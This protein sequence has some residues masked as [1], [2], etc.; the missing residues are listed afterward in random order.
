MP[1]FLIRGLA[2]YFAA[3][4]MESRA[5]RQSSYTP[6]SETSSDDDKQI[7]SADL[8][9]WQT[10]M[11]WLIP[12]VQATEYQIV[13]DN[14]K[15]HEQIIIDK[16]TK[17]LPELTLDWMQKYDKQELLEW[18]ANEKKRQ[19]QEE[20]DRQ[21]KLEAR[22]IEEAR[23]RARFGSSFTLG[24]QDIQDENKISQND[25]KGNYVI[26]ILCVLVFI[27]ALIGLWVYNSPIFDEKRHERDVHKYAAIM[28]EAANAPMTEIV[29]PD[30]L[31]F[32]MNEEEFNSLKEQRK[33][34]IDNLFGTHYD[35]LL[36]NVHYIGDAV[37]GD[38]YNDNKLSSYT[39]RIIGQ[40]SNGTFTYLTNNDV[41]NICNYY[42][43]CLKEDYTL[44][45][46]PDLFLWEKAHNYI[47]TKNN[48]VIELRYSERYS[49]SLTIT[50]KNL[51]FSTSNEIKSTSHYEERLSSTQ[52]ES[53]DEEPITSVLTYSSDSSS[54]TVHPRGCYNSI[55]M[56]WVEGGVFSM[57]DHDGYDNKPEH[58]V[59]VSN[60]Y[61]ATTE[62]TQSLWRE[63]MGT[64]GSNLA[65]RLHAPQKPADNISWDD[66]H[67]FIDALN[68]RTDLNF[69][70][71]TEA[72][73]E[74]AAKGGNKSCGYTYSE[75]DYIN[76]VAWWAVNA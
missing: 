63:I 30:C 19:Q 50:C 73:W 5:R 61:I 72:E 29:T 9:S 70:L 45:N 20:V 14:P 7:S 10:Q 15:S 75:S 27:L 52:N 42:K 26:P 17:E 66:A 69:R 68:S 40:I 43:S 74:Y 58:K 39:I 49:E 76:R 51:H 31:R 25:N 24:N 53:V 47:F 71:P 6:P 23:G 67:Q 41:N 64:N 33:I 18:M 2:R 4:V 48:M 12:F 54:I 32:D 62:A 65:E 59:E 22:R 55:T 38:K 35:W 28:N 1:S 3:S 46:L 11:R 8:A 16:N 37:Y 44:T 34:V 36:G 13:I 56:I 60:F 57:G 21:K